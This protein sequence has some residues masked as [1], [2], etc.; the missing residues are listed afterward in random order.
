MIKSN[1]YSKSWQCIRKIYQA[2]RNA[3][4]VHEQALPS[5]IFRVHEP[6]ARKQFMW[7]L[8]DG[9][10]TRLYQREDRLHA[11]NGMSL[12]VRAF[13]LIFAKL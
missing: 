4:T 6:A 1:D 3:S 2:E 7:V 5:S 9:F 11:R 13:V 8:R 12:L 10:S